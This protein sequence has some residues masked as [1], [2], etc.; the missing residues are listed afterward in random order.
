MSTRKPKPTFPSEIE[1]PSKQLQLVTVSAKESKA[2][3]HP[4]GG[5]LDEFS[6]KDY[7]AATKRRL[8]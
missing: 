2:P 3:A 4:R 6:L 8:H 5:S 7:L 1:L